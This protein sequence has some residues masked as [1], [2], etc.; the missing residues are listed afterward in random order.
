M[1][2]LTAA[3]GC[4]IEHIPGH[5]SSQSYGT[6]EE[7][8]RP[9]LEQRTYRMFGKTVPV[10]RL[11][12]WFGDVP[13]TYSGLTHDPSPYTPRLRAIKGAVEHVAGATFNSCLAN[14]YRSGYDSV[15]FHA[16][17]EPELGPEPTI[18][19]V[20]FGATR[21]FRLKAKEGSHKLGF[22]LGHGD[23]IIMG[24]KTQKLYVHSIP[25]TKR[26]VGLNLTFRHTETS[27]T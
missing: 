4:R 20:S 1:S 13:Y 16:D 8:L 6:L 18:A 2:D 10:P 14:L 9:F 21:L 25:R 12:A 5:F 26:P 23:V 19:S 11:T 24:G 27:K 22:D 15:G 17:D 3:R 7:E